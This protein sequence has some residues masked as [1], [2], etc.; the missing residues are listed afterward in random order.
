MNQAENSIDYIELPLS[1]AGATKAFYSAVFGWEFQ[2][3]G[4]D[5]LSFS[6][7]GVDGGFNRELDSAAEG[8]GPM[9]VLYS[10][11]LEEKISA[12]ARAGGRVSK[13]TYGFPGGERFHFIDPNGNEV[14]VWRQVAGA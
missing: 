8:V 13:A 9:V 4:P 2:D 1:N 5:Y 14:L 10:D 12:I 7:A 11:R 3:W 6:G